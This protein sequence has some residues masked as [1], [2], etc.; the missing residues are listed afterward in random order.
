[1]YNDVIKSLNYNYK[2]RPMRQEFNKNLV[3]NGAFYMF[4][5]K[6]FNYYKNRL[7]G[8]IGFYEMP[9]RR[10]IEIDEK[11]DLNFVTKILAYKNYFFSKKN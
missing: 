3:E 7:F 11:E 5:V 8:K 4:K 1:M 9:E 2:K 6:K 10:S